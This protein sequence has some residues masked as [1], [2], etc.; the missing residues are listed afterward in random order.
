MVVPD[1]RVPADK[2]LAEAAALVKL[3]AGDLARLLAANTPLP[4]VR[5][6]SLED[7]A[8]I[9]QRLQTFAIST[10]IVSDKDLRM[11]DPV[12]VRARSLEADESQV[13]LR[14]R[15]EA[16]KVAIPWNHLVLLV[17]GRVLTKRVEVKER[18]VRRRANQIEEATE[19]YSDDKVMDLYSESPDQSFRISS[20]RFDYSSLEGKGMVAAENFSLLMRLICLKA[21]R[22]VVDD[23]YNSLRQLLDLVWP[24]EQQIESLGWRR[25]RLG[26]LSFAA[27]TESSSEIQFTRYSRLLYLLKRKMPSKEDHA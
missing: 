21:S 11:D 20:N 9:R 12:P 3:D 4:L 22:I 13:T 17:T 7:C 14:H 16:E 19:L 24:A 27:V 23:S 15:P 5:A 2:N 10:A 25:E 6:A 26:K 1:P 8:L 18:K